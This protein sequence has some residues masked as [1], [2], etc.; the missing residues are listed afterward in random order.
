M[1]TVLFL[2]ATGGVCNSTL[3]HALQSAPPTTHCVALVRTPQKLRDMLEAQNLTQQQ[4]SPSRLTI[5]AGDALDTK[6][7]RQAIL[8]QPPKS[9]SPSP[10]LPV[11]IV[12]GLGGLGQ[13]TFNTCA[14]LEIIKLENPHICTEGAQA[15]V[16]TLREIYSN[17]TS[18]Q[19]KPRLI[20][21]STTGVTRG[22]EDVPMA[23]R[24]MYHKSLA[25]PHRDKKAMEDVFR[26]EVAN[27]SWNVGP[28]NP[29]V[30]GVF[31]S[32]T[33]IR[34]TLL[35][36]GTGA[37]AIGSGKGWEKVKA[38]TEAKPQL[39]YNIARVDVGG[40]VWMRVLKNFLS[41]GEDND[42]ELKGGKW[43]GEMCSLTT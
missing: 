27:K 35:S 26:A 8:Q 42:D 38:G 10:Q 30:D 43:E 25:V 41:D 7:L 14:P 40:W 20:F 2:G 9:T 1:E 31:K 28:G 33:G 21:I 11:A 5:L 37:E 39:G 32:A 17:I 22:P 16:S 18:T 36:G 4:L 19:M 34:P 6:S 3:V 15:L 23:M 13:L 29:K 12:T 24:F